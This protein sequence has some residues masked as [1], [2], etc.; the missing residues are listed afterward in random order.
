MADSVEA[1]VKRNPER[2]T[3]LAKSLS[4]Y[5][6]AKEDGGDLKWMADG[7]PGFSLF[8]DAAVKMQ[9]NELKIIES[10]LGYSVFKVDAKS[11]F[12][13][14][15]K[16]AVL[17]RNIDPSNQTFQDTYMKA[18]AF[19]GENKTPEAFEKALAFM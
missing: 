11:P 19:A 9:P 10:R 3:E 18:S 7:N 16:V 15:I 17:Q 5:P 12:H 6:T 13:K 1:L 14:K 8:F 4:D 2:F